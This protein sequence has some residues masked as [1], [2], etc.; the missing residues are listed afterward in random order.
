MEILNSKQ[1]QLTFDKGI[2][3]VPSDA[4][5]SDNALD[6]SLGLVYDNG[7]HRV[8]QK[9]KVKF[10]D[11]T[12]KILSVHKFNEDERFIGQNVTTTTIK[13][14]DKNGDGGTVLLSSTSGNVQVTSIGKTLIVS[15]G[16]GLHYFLW[17]GNG[18][19]SLGA[20][21][22]PEFQFWLTTG[23]NTINHNFPWVLNKG[24]DD[25]IVSRS[26]DYPNFLYK[27]VDGK[28]EDW[29][30]LVVGLYAKNKKQ[31]AQKKGFCLPF[32]VRTALEL[33]DGSYTH[34]SNP[35]LLFP[36]VTSNTTVVEGD[37]ELSMVTQYLKLKFS[38]AKDL[39]D[40]NDI[41]KDVVVFAT[42]GIEVY[43]L[44]VDQKIENQH[45][46]DGTH[47]TYYDYVL[48]LAGAYGK[49]RF[50]YEQDLV[51]HGRSYVD[52]ENYSNVDPFVY[53][54]SK[55]LDEDIK[56][57]SVFYKLCS[58]G[59][60]S[61]S[62]KDVADY[63]DTHTLENLTTQEF[64]KEDD[65]FS[66]SS[67][68]ARLIYAYNSRLNLA[69]VKRSIFEGFKFFTPFSLANAYNANVYIETDSG[70]KLATQTLV[71][72]NGANLYFFYPDSR[73]SVVTINGNHYKLTEH[74]ALNGAYYFAGIENVINWSQPAGDGGS[75]VPSS[76]DT[77]P[78]ILDNYIMTSE[79][80]NPFLF[81]AEGYNRVGT[82][83]VIG[84]S[85]LTQA[86]SEGQ[87]GQYPLLVFSES[88]IWA[89]SL[90]NTGTFNSVHPLSREVALKDNPCITQTDGAVFFASKKGLMVIVGSQVTCVSEQLSG[91][92]NT[93]MVGGTEQTIDLGNFATFLETAVIAYDYR[94]SLLWIFDKFHTA[95]WI[96][97][98][99]SKAFGKF[100]FTN[101]DVIDNVVNYYPDYLLQRTGG[102][103][104]SLLD[105][106]NINTDADT[107]SGTIITRPM[108][109]ENA[110]ALKS[111]LQVR[112][113][114]QFGGGQNELRLRIFAS[115]NLG[116]WC[117]LHSLGGMPWKYYR[118]R[119]DF[120]NLVATDRFGGTMLITQERR[121]NK[122]R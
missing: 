100:E 98:I 66:R 96:Y 64:L 109:L 99:K 120:N 13:W 62:D 89:M 117:E 82:G 86:L 75:D 60:K 53:K 54:T 122:L 36:C 11:F 47:M 112:H 35:I 121:T 33:Y 87:F 4:L 83:E 3:N 61:F 57:A 85:T 41:V 2:T 22:E 103:V 17:K 111:I 107:Y 113:V 40:W 104:Y 50:S 80:N 76:Y 45:A 92:T 68:I 14:Y 71:G 105:R 19:E 24:N 59:L 32:F 110:L 74:P 27:I 93:F 108:K 49:T 5:C 58:I 116:S 106:P 21:P 31:I 115:N 9:P 56:G 44:L 25:G 90:S 79:V 65:Y 6:E 10:R 55:E 26:G 51:K 23:Y 30:N 12:D 7:E 48:N 101:D 88:G 18:Y 78:E 67:L 81:K 102:R 114:K 84:M 39:S 15:D 119:Y 63:I 1:Q 77:Y 72:N 37:W 20:I 97:S 8:I 42:P 34:I 118:F 69:G 94:D 91:K 52:R 16:N 43:D 28:Q 95:C 38:Q 70:N 73:A 46:G 29:N